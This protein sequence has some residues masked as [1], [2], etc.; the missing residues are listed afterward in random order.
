MLCREDWA[1]L[2]IFYNFFN[3]LRKLNDLK[4]KCL[5]LIIGFLKY[6]LPASE[7]F[8][9][10]GVLLEVEWFFVEGLRKNP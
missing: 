5:T 6:L 9:F 1:K 2:D 4:R 10:V 7:W 8:L 3:I